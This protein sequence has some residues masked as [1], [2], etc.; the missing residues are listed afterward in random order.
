MNKNFF[1]LL[2]IV[3]LYLLLTP[4]YCNAETNA[5]FT[6]KP[7]INKQFDHLSTSYININV[8]PNQTLQPQL[9]VTNLSSEPLLIEITPTNALTTKNGGIHYTP[10]NKTQY[11]AITK[12]TH[13]LSKMI[14]IQKEISLAPY[15]NKIVSFKL[16]SPS[17]DAGTFLGGLLFKTKNTNEE[18][19]ELDDKEVQ[20]KITSEVAF[21]MAIQLNMPKKEVPHINFLKTSSE[22]TPSGLQILQG[23][24]N[25]SA[26]IA[27]IDNFHYQIKD[28]KEKI[29]FKGSAE[30]IKFAPYTEIQYPI[31]WK[32]SAI[33]EG[34]Y[35]IEIQY[36]VGQIHFNKKSEFNIS[37]KEANTYIEKNQDNDQKIFVK[38][39]IPIFVWILIIG[40]FICVAFLIIKLH[41]NNKKQN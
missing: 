28:K 37:K 29:L 9:E 40:L 18:S 21:A 6:V 17:V 14:H 10:L 26:T 35:T 41:K 34:D 4:K 16:K 30:T 24:E 19:K 27:I 1:V 39:E 3:V 31:F 23:I 12:S 15:E 22:F 36:E 8:E 7:F 32:E 38:Q 5:S 20:L 25:D 2:G 11:S 33:K 13:E